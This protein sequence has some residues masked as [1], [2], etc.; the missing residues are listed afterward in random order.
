[1][2][3]YYT[4]DQIDATFVSTD[5]LKE[6]A[7][8]TEVEGKQNQLVSGT[9]IKTINGESILGKGNIEIKVSSDIDLSEFA[10]KQ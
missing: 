8:K 7:T 2:S 1:M 4:K 10:T 5:S 9:N 6:Y 3:N